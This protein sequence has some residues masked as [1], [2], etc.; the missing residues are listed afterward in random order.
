MIVGELLARQQAVDKTKTLLRTFAHGHSHRRVQFDNQRWLNVKQPVLEQLD[1]AP[2]RG[3]RGGTLGVNGRNGRLQSVGA[4]TA[5]C[6]SA[7][8]ERDA[9]GDLL[10]VPQR[11]ILLLQQDQV[12]VGRGSRRPTRLLQ[13]HEPHEARRLR[14][15][16]QFDQ[17]S[18]Q[19][20]RLAAEFGACRCRPPSI[21]S[22]RHR[23]AP[24]DRS[25]RIQQQPA[26]VSRW[27]A[28]RILSIDPLEVWSRPIFPGHAGSSQIVSIDIETGELRTHTTGPGVKVSPRYTGLKEI[29][30]VVIFGDKQG[31]RFTSDR[32]GASGAMRAPHGHRTG[33][34]WCTTRPSRGS[35]ACRLA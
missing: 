5:R 22:A 6:Q 4:E 8:G 9:F 35:M 12:S 30:Y 17:E 2:I 13:Q 15:P 33:R 19:P 26:M 34:G 14:L 28:H 24:L 16:N 29:A 32:D 21:L 10:L 25:W 23:A 20:Y 18:A 7:F 1:L 11:P 3:C 31:L 27:P